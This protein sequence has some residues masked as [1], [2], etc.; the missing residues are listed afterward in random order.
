MRGN[1][2][3]SVRTA[4]TTCRTLLRRWV[5]PTALLMIVVT[6]G[7]LVPLPPAY[8]HDQVVSHTPAADERVDAAPNSITLTL[9]STPLDVGASVSVLDRE[10]NVWSEGA[11]RQDGSSIVQDLAEHVPDGVYEVRWRVVSND[12]HALSDSFR[13]LVGIGTSSELLTAPFNHGVVTS[14]AGVASEHSAGTEGSP[15]TGTA[16]LAVS[17]I[18][19][20]GFALVLLGRGRFGPSRESSATRKPN[21]EPS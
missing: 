11:P 13:F 10:Q 4:G 18:A 9:T 5:V 15:V 3:S 8:A 1:L 14:A 21:G 2:R 7:A 12:G 16:L 17:G 6:A 19:V 20:L